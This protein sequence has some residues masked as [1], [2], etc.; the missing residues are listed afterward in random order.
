MTSTAVASRLYLGA[1]R[2]DALQS[3]HIRQAYSDLSRNGLSP[4]NVR[5]AHRLLH[6]A[7]QDAVLLGLVPAN[8]LDAVTAPRAPYR[9]MNTLSVEESREL[10]RSTRNDWLHPL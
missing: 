2:L 9:E 4:L 10:F 6:A 3:S 1:I 5:Q 8:P 7:M